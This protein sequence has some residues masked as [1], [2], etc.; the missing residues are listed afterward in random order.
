[1]DVRQEEERVLSY[2]IVT[3]R[4]C[5]KYPKQPFHQIAF[6]VQPVVIVAED[7]PIPNSGVSPLN[8][9]DHLIRL[10][11]LVGKHGV[12][13]DPPQQRLGLCIK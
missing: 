1:M 7:R 13:V 4:K 11:T 8:P 9:C 10:I 6:L 12:S 2:R 5:V 3:R